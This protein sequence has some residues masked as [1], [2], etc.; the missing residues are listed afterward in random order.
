MPIKI[1]NITP[2]DVDALLPLANETREHH[3]KFLGGYFA[4]LDNEVEK[5]I[6]KSW[7]NE[8]K[9]I[10]LLAE[11][12]SQIAGMLLSEFK[13]NPQLEF[14]DIIFVHNFAVTKAMRGK[15][16]GRRL[17][18]E[19]YDICKQRNIK[20]IKLGVFNKNTAAYT[21]YEDFGFEPQEQK[22]SLKIK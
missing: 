1:R 10:C 16:I 8:D 2:Q 7:V 4:P 15:G 19:L 18:A 9:N 21:F 20:E 17:M 22:M 3:R 6:I 14:S 12:D 13:H 5:Q 11:D